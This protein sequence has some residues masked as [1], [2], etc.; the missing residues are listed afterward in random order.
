VETVAPSN[1]DAVYIEVWP[2]DKEFM[3]LH[4]IVANAQKLGGGK[5]VII[6][7]YI[8]P[9]RATNVCLVNALIFA[10][11]GFYLEL[12]EP[13]KLL[14][15]PYFP[16][17]GSLDD[18]QKDVL[19]RYYDFMVRYENVLSLGTTD[20]TDSR[21][22]ALTIADVRTQS[23]RSRDRVAVIVRKGQGFETFNLINLLGLDTPNWDEPLNTTPT[24]VTDLQVT[25]DVSR[26]VARLWAASPD[27]ANL[28]LQAI[29]FTSA[30]DTISFSL[31]RLDYWSMILVE[32]NR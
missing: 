25:V 2:P 5:P 20:V 18:T 16:K 14:A 11:G 13:C 24:P 19:S 7:A 21:A 32:Y 23:L 10:S 22:K 31:P 1:E 30:N 28:A 29:P 15:D 4:R 9:E 26:P 6:A 8:L 12:G 27:N 3:D 17:Y